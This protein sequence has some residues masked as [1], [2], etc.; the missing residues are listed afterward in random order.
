MLRHLLGE[1]GTLSEV[2][3]LNGAAME[4]VEKMG[5]TVIPVACVSAL[6]PSA[7]APTRRVIRQI[8][9]ASPG[10][11]VVA[12]VWAPEGN[13]EEIKPRLA[14]ASPDLVATS[15]REARAQIAE[16]LSAAAPKAVT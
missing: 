14:H 15:L 13:L 16:L 1:A 10:V 7:L 6:P 12:G 3:N 9:T 8:Q 11:K 5:G 4:G 2:I